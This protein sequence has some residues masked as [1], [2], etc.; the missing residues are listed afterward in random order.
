MEAI[1]ALEI[2][3]LD[4]ATRKETIA[5]PTTVPPASPRSSDEHANAQSACPV[6][7]AA[8]ESPQSTTATLSAPGT[9]VTPI[10]PGEKTPKAALKAAAKARRAVAKVENPPCCP[11]TFP[12]RDSQ[13]KNWDFCLDNEWEVDRLLKHHRR[14]PTAAIARRDL[15]WKV[16]KSSEQ[17]CRNLVE[18]WT[19][20][21]H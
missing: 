7:P 10:G 21:K 14:P 12:V 4:A 5:A 2:W 19:W 11:V 1:T 8:T 16:L 13:G 9:S 17:D 3:V 6:L 20:F 18:Q 15:A